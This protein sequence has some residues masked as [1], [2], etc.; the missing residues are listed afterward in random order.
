MK[1]YKYT[2]LYVVIT[3][4]RD[5]LCQPENCFKKRSWFSAIMCPSFLG[6]KTLY[7]IGLIASNLC[8][9]C[10][11]FLDF[12]VKSPYLDYNNDRRG[13]EIT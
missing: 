11:A 1:Y 13:F 2:I 8:V 10:V 5:L 9:G 3:D 7:L 6:H 12:N 4:T